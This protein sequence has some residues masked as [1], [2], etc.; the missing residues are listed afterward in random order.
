MKR[1][2]DERVQQ[3][4]KENKKHLDEINE[5]HENQ[6][7]Q[8]KNDLQQTFQIEHQAQM[9]YYLQTIDEL[10]RQHE[11]LLFEQKNQQMTQ[12]ELGEEFLVERQQF[13]E[14]IQKLEDEIDRIQRTSHSALDEEK[15]KF[16]EKNDEFQCLIKEFDDY[17]SSFKTDSDV[18]NRLNEQVKDSFFICFSETNVFRS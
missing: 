18:V 11:Q 6:L 17:K 2:Y 13:H 15:R 5:K 7:E 3:L 10:K 1:K 16:E 12:N 14:K 4:N 8:T 9:K